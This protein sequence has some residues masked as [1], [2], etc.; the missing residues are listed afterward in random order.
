MAHHNDPFG[1]MRHFYSQPERQRNAQ[2][3]AVQGQ[4]YS[5]DDL[6]AAEATSIS[7][8]DH[9]SD[10]EDM[11]FYEFVPETWRFFRPV[12]YEGKHERTEELEPKAAK[13]YEVAPDNEELTGSQIKKKQCEAAGYVQHSIGHRLFAT[14]GIHREDWMEA[15]ERSQI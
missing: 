10:S 9:P 12:F 1:D 6:H 15:H 8:R 2:L 14:H 13:M 7:Y 3:D 5:D 11:T 4:I